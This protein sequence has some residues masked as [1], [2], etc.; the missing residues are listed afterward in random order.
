MKNIMKSQEAFCAELKQ[1]VKKYEQKE[2]EVFIEKFKNTDK[3]FDYVQIY[4]TELNN[5]IK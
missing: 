5:R 1:A 2:L 3:Y 4:Q